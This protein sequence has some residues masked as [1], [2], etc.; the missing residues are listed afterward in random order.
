MPYK[1]KARISQFLTNCVCCGSGTSKSF[2]RAHE[3]KCKSCATG[4]S[5][6][7][8]YAQW[9]EEAAIMRHLDEKDYHPGEN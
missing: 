5:R 2:A 3:G 6:I 8:G 4:V 1:G 9:N 7:D